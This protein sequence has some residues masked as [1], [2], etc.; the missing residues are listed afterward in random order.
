M[1]LLLLIIAATVSYTLFDVFAS[2]AGNRIDSNLSAFLFNIIG[3]AIPIVIYVFLKFG[4]KTALIAATSSGIIYSVLA[5]VSVALFSILLIKVFEKGGLAYVMPLIYG[6]S[7]VLASLI[8]W[9][10]FKESI[11][12]LH[13]A[14]MATVIVGIVLIIVSKI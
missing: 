9:L 7:I 13:F 4:K 2:R 10:L 12:T 14:G 3:A 11:S 6:G 8:G 5:G 1:T